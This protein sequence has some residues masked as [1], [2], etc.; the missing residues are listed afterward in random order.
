[1]KTYFVVNEQA[2]EEY[3]WA[4]R[5]GNHKE[6]DSEGWKERK[7][8]PLQEDEPVM[9]KRP[10]TKNVISMS[11][12]HQTKVMASLV[13]DEIIYNVS[14]YRIRP[15]DSCLLFGDVSGKL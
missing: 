14:D 3:V 6:T 8:A 5:S 12:D 10:K 9:T 7:S 15:Y 11:D 13:P 1:M 4:M 2:G